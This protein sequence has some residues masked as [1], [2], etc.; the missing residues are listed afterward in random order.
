M[1]GNQVLGHF[2][3]VVS[4]RG[5]EY[6]VRY[7]GLKLRGKFWARDTKLSFISL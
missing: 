2:E 1:A 4:T 7:I 5:V 6:I 3:F